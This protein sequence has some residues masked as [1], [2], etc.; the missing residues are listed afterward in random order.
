VIYAG[1]EDFGEVAF[2]T[3]LFK[4]FNRIET[5]QL[6]NVELGEVPAWE[7]FDLTTYDRILTRAFNC[8]QR[9]YSAAYVMAPPRLGAER[10]HSN[11]LRLLQHMMKSGLPE[12]LAGAPTMQQAFEL[13]RAQ[14]GIGDFLGFQFLIDL[15]YSDTLEF[16]EMDF[17]VAGPGARDGIRKCFGNAAN[18]IE[19]DVIR[20]MADHQDEH[21]ARLQLKFDG[22]GGRPLK[23]IDC[24]NLFC[25][26]D[27]YARMA[28][29]TVA[30]ISGRTRI[31]QKFT[32]VHKPVTA[33]FPPKWRINPGRRPVAD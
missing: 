13:L 2:R 33:W 1:P 6:L 18:G 4:I 20:Y 19:A 8:G 9:L 7:N 25:E 12:K 32:P 10:K 3:L 16:D 17:V 26:V 5:W 11:H 27:K 21:F 31:K 30:G 22:L 24:Q 15:N 29:P 28:H 23:L 14:P